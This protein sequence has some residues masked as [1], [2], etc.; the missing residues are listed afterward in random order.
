MS[1]YWFG[2]V[3]VILLNITEVFT[4]MIAKSSSCFANVLLLAKGTG[5]AINNISRGTRETISDLNGLF[6]LYD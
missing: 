5:N 2:C 3:L 4:K 6:R 1:G